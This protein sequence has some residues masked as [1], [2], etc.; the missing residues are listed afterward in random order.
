MKNLS[1]TEP[2]LKKSVAYKKKRE[3][4]RLFSTQP[5]CCL[6]FSWI[7]LELL[8]R[9]CLIHISLI[10]L[11]HFLY[12]L[13]LYP[14]PDACLFMSYLCDLFLIFIFI[15]TDTILILLSFQNISYYFWLIT[16]MKN[17]NIFQK[18]KVQPQ[19]VA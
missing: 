11:R 13:Y 17:V 9:C 2:E 4:Q 8:L 6:T 12:L 1:N 14:C 7:E 18:A 10:I 15:F 19:S 16:W 3:K 5:Q